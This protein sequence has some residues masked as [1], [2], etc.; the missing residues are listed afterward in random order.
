M[1]AAALLSMLLFGCIKL[2]AQP[3]VLWI[4]NYSGVNTATCMDVHPI[5]GGGWILGG[6]T[7]TYT[8]SSRQAWIMKVNS[9][10]DS[11]TSTTYQFGVNDEIA[12]MI[13][14]G[15]GGWICGGTYTSAAHLGKEFQIFRI[16]SANNV[17]WEH[18]FGGTLTEV[19]HDIIASPKVDSFCSARH[20]LSLAKPGTCR[21]VKTTPRGVFEWQRSYDDGSLASGYSICLAAGGGYILAGTA[22]DSATPENGNDLWLV[23]I[24]EDAYVQWTKSFGGPGDDIAYDIQL[25]PDSGF[26]VAGVKGESNHWTGRPWLLRLNAN[27]DSLW[28]ASSLGRAT[29]EFRSV[30]YDTGW[31]VSGVGKLFRLRSSR[32][33][34]LGCPV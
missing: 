24:D 7:G 32:I 19:C 33:G 23:K 29:G 31:R 12:A 28:S 30:E 17:I 4:R 2:L 3:E 15:D 5:P 13:P 21:V 6:Y 22:N 18:M 25:L 14:A 16:D 26:I 20:I 10:G 1:K 9:G 27:G 34:F 11:L 8:G